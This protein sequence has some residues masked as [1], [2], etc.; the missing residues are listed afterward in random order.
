ML[1]EKAHFLKIL[2]ELTQCVKKNYFLVTFKTFTEI[3]GANALIV[4]LGQQ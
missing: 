1:H 4:I 2:F 3:C